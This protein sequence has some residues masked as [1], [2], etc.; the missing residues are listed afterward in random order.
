MASYASDRVSKSAAVHEFF[1]Q[2]REEALRDGVVVAVAGGAHAAARAVLVEH[3]AVLLARVREYVE[4]YYTER[5][6]QGLA[7][8]L[9]QSREAPSNDNCS[10]GASRS[11]LGGLLNFYFKQAG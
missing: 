11:R 10:R 9:I 3:A 4:H 8:R 2:G 5:Y 1:L 6:H 7:G